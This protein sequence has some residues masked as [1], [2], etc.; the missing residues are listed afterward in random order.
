MSC[1]HWIYKNSLLL[2]QKA[3]LKFSFDQLDLNP[4]LCIQAL[5]ARLLRHKTFTGNS[6]EMTIVD[7]NLPFL[8]I[9]TIEIQHVINTEYNLALLNMLAHNFKKIRAQ[10]LKISLTRTSIKQLFRTEPLP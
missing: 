2:K 9:I 6:R 5:G 4:L 7:N 10:E 3:L 8:H 1:N